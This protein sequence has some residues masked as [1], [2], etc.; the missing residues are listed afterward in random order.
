VYAPPGGFA[1]VTILALTRRA[2]AKMIFAATVI[3]LN[4]FVPFDYDRKRK[5][6]LDGK[7]PFDVCYWV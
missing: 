1:K 3:A 7:Q 4:I 2:S 6:P 5:F